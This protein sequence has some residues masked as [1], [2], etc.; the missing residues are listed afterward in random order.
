MEEFSPV[1]RIFAKRL[2]EYR[3][4]DINLDDSPII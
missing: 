4:E 1:R 2:S 3:P